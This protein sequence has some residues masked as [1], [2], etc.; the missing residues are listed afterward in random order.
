MISRILKSFLIGF[1]IFAIN[2]SFGSNVNKTKESKNILESSEFLNGDIEQTLNGLKARIICSKVKLNEDEWMPGKWLEREKILEIWENSVSDIQNQLRDL[3][4]A[5][6]KKIDE[7][8]VSKNDPE[9]NYEFI[10][11]LYD[12]SLYDKN[13]E[14]VA[15][16]NANLNPAEKVKLMIVEPRKKNLDNDKIKE[17]VAAEAVAPINANLNLAEEVKLMIVELRKKNLDNM[18]KITKTDNLID[19]SQ[20]Q[21]QLK[22]VERMLKYKFNNELDLKNKTN[23]L[24]DN[25][26]ILMESQLERPNVAKN[27]ISRQKMRIRLA[28]KLEA[29]SKKK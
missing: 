5:V 27:E 21:A 28:Q 12:E 26:N 9:Y 8:A 17:K 22:Y 13:K 4:D 1:M 2:D 3:R 15:A 23:K 7:M 14:A 16:T 6:L 11:S 24:Q 18:V 19:L 10:E 29:R 25:V 20:K